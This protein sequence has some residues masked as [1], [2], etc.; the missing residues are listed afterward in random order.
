MTRFVVDNSSEWIQSSRTVELLGWTLLHSLWQIALVGIVFAIV[1]RLIRK[2]AHHLELRYWLGVCSLMIMIAML[3]ATFIVMAAHTNEPSGHE[4]TV[5]SAM[6]SN[7]KS[8]VSVEPL[9]EPA[10]NIESVGSPLIEQ[11]MQA[12]PRLRSPMDAGSSFVEC[13]SD[14]LWML[15]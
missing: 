5:A 8:A 13:R 15:R 14:R 3:P 6:D 12:R 7:P 10:G 4:T 1:D 11:S 9:G 2:T